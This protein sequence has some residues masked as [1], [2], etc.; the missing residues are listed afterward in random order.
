M[1]LF[2]DG[3]ILGG[4]AVILEAATRSPSLPV[5]CKGR[6]I[7]SLPPPLTVASGRPGAR[8][9]EILR[10]ETIRSQQKSRVKFS[11]PPAA[12]LSSSRNSK[13]AK[14][15]DRFLFNGVAQGGN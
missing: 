15:E 14:A 10:F 9:G 12:T 7:M 3:G 2:V 6:P 5:W 8:F 4:L 11:A 13:S 1:Y